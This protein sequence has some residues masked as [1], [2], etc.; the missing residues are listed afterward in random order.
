MV[1]G[2]A[3][4][5]TTEVL[6]ARIEDQLRHERGVAYSV[7]AEALPVS[8][9]RRLVVVAADARSGQEDLAASVLWREVR[10]LADEGPSEAELHHQRALLAGYLADPRTSVEEPRALARGRVTG[11]PARTPTGLRNAADA[12]TPDAV[13]GAAAGLRDG[14]VL[15]LPMGTESAPAGLERLPEWSAEAVT[16]REFR[17]RR[18]S[19]LPRGTRLVVG[20]E[21]ASLVQGAGEWLTVRWVDAVGLVRIWTDEWLL[22]GRDGTTVRLAAGDWHDGAR[23]IDLARAAV[24]ADLQAVGDDVVGERAVLVF[25]APVHRVRE[26]IGVSRQ[27]ATLVSNAE[28]TALTVEDDL[29]AEARA[30]VV[31]EGVG[32]RPVTLV[33]RQGH[34]DLEYLL[35]VRSREID[36][37]TWGSRAGDPRLLAD[38]VGR[39]PQEL[40]EVLAA[41]GGPAELLARFVA[42]VGLPEQV[43]GL[44]AGREVPGAEQVTG[45]GIVGGLR[46]AVRGDFAPAPGGGSWVDR[47]MQVSRSRPAWYR[48]VNAVE[49]VGFGLLAWYLVVSAGGDLTSWRGV[50]ALVAGLF[51]LACMWDTRPPRRVADEREQSRDGGGGAA[52]SPASSDGPAG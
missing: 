48:A 9:D 17:P 2:P 15:A 35:I 7:T 27:R 31:A 46:A 34:A 40:A 6:R 45:Q 47:W 18:K 28:W 51:A 1:V 29:P 10:R 52:L 11:I 30:A 12:L 38:A 26:A 16:G 24:P 33:L 8:A 4:P 49:A 39:D 20:D 3:V 19:F 36:R 50:L 21:G 41:S 37:H 43:P 23:A 32:G 14:S 13:R 25:R 22:T 44:L 5:G 42:A